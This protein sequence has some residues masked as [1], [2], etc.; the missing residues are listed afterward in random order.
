MA[1]KLAPKQN[2]VLTSGAL[3]TITLPVN[4]PAGQVFTFR[5]GRPPTGDAKVPVTFRISKKVLERYQALG[6]DWRARMAQKLG[7]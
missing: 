5:R 4:I 2:V 6:V 3:P 7:E 1:I